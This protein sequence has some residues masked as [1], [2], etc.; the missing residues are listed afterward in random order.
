MIQQDGAVAGRPSQE[1]DVISGAVVSPSRGRGTQSTTTRRGGNR[2]SKNKSKNKGT[3]SQ[4]T[5]PADVLTSST[6]KQRSISNP[7]T[8]QELINRI[9]SMPEEMLPQFA[10]QYIEL[11]VDT[12]K[13]NT[14]ERVANFFGQIA[15]ES[16]RGNAEYVYYFSGDYLKEVF[17]G[18]VRP[19]DKSDFIY[20]NPPSVTTRPYGFAPG[21]APWNVGG[22]AD[23]YY[24]GRNGNTRGK[25]SDAKNSL[26]VFKPDEVVYDKKNKIFKHQTNPHLYNGSPE[27]YAYRGHGVIQITGKVQYERMNEFFGRNGKYEKN[28]IDFL[29][30]PEIC[31]YNWNNKLGP[32]NKF[33]FLSA[34]MWWSNNDGVYINQIS[35]S[36]TRQI[37]RAV[38]G[39]EGGY[40][41]RH[42]QVERYFYYLNTGSKPAATQKGGTMNLSEP[43]T[44]TKVIKPSELKFLSLNNATRGSLSSVFVATL[45]LKNFTN[46]SFFVSGGGVIGPYKDLSTNS[47]ID[48]HNKG[49]QVFTINK[50]GVAKIYNNSDARSS[51]IWGNLVYAAA[52][53]PRLLDNG[54]A[55]NGKAN[56]SFLR[57][58]GRTAIGIKPSGELVIYVSTNKYIHN[59]INDLQQLGCVDAINFDGGGSTF[60]YLNGKPI[61]TSNRSFPNVMS[62]A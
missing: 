7:A 34:L 31:S 50:Q 20:K 27:G 35:L 6:D 11:M 17:G 9:K 60:L 45:G 52:G 49:Y 40:E 25:V 54:K 47:S 10:K 38:R 36:T 4:R 32:P 13:I 33:A 57:L 2:V 3:S 8:R 53:W 28:D 22:W 55:W 48:N 39:S 24:G 59:V 5:A 58:T 18:R 23:Q 12:F 15:S 30:H 14:R 62:W 19:Q 21:K 51:P 46:L 56:A 29:E 26:Q 42:K 37:T 61:I 41:K 43:P 44:F 16:L 1:D